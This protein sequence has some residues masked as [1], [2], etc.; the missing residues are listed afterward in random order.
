MA[1]KKVTIKD[2]AKLAEVSAGTVDRVL[3]N[4]GKVSEIK[5][6]KVEAV[7]KDIN[8]EPNLI[9]KTLKNNRVFQLVAILPYAHTDEYWQKAKRGLLSALDEFRSFGIAL[10]CLEFDIA[11]THSF[12]KV[13]QDAI[14]E[15]PDG[16][17]AV[18]FFHEE[19][20]EVFVQFEANQIPYLTFNTHLPGMHPACAIGQDLKQSGSL[21]A[22]LA[23]MSR[24]KQGSVALVHVNEHPDNTDH[25]REKEEGFKA[26]LTEQ[27][28]DL[29]DFHSISLDESRDFDGELSKAIEAIPNLSAVHVSTSKAFMI[30]PILKHIHPECT[31]SGYDLVQPNV[32]LLREGKI[33]FL[34]DQKPMEQ[35]YQAIARFTDH[36]VFKK[37]IDAEYLLPL[38][39][40]F[41]EN[42]NSLVSA[43]PTEK[44]A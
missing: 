34:I 26:Y 13:C 1:D 2:I 10:A 5:R 12:Q 14:A 29:I 43:A 23:L 21:A 16:I 33:Q 19:A 28:I 4:R 3:H 40:A 25:A 30:D 37:T 44:I 31:L 17:I 22:Q 11:D 41:K 27:G 38:H 9:A 39:I 35:A 24:K 18:P 32:T 7:L 36:L 20:R 15:Q 6:K 42:I 8:Y